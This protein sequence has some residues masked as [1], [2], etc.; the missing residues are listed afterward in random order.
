MDSIRVGT[1]CRADAPAKINLF[2][3]V[4]GK[5][6]DGF[7]EIET[8]IGAISLRDT[9]YFRED[10]E[11]LVR[12]NCSWASGMEAGYT[13]RSEEGRPSIAAGL[14]SLP[15]PADNTV[16]R[17][18]DQFRRL[19]GISSG[20]TVRIVK[21]I[22]AAAGLGGASSDAAAA[23]SLANAVWKVGWEHQRLVELAADIGS[24]VPF[25]L[26]PAS[27]LGRDGGMALC[28]GRGERI[29]AVPVANRLHLVVVRPPSGLLTAD[30]YAACQPAGD[31]VSAGPILAALRIGNIREA[32]RHLF[33]RLEPAAARLSPWIQ[34]LQAVFQRLDLLGFQMSGSGSSFFGICRHRRHARRAAGLLRAASI[35]QVF[36][37]SSVPQRCGISAVST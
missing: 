17:A 23:L 10:P 14:G 15:D 36:A 37:T 6:S 12:V 32:G 20:A 24:D 33:N 30:V 5:R 34:R 26:G 19:A 1:I 4:L 16:A 29:D 21:R 22:P 31:P 13:A 18:L 9:L 25:F 11:G 7:H 3:E 2:L 28:R 8:L 27:A 35:G